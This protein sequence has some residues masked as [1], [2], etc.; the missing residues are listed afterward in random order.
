MVIYKLEPVL[1]NISIS[2]NI[3]KNVKNASKIKKLV[4]DGTI[5][6][7]ILKS[8]LVL[9]EFELLVA[10]NK[11][12]FQKSKNKL[13][14][15]NVFSEILFNLSPSNKISE[16]FKLFGI[17]EATTNLAVICLE[18]NYEDIHNLVDG[19]STVVSNL[20]ES[21]NKE[22]I[23]KLYKINESELKTS[24]LLDC[25]VSQLAAKDIR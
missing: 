1:S 4:E 16:C 7:A 9:D 21:C 11:A 17:D 20:A 22:A 8:D 13:K 6:A 5:H 24:T 12:F 19:D 14:T 23:L 10:T 3:Y 2:L 25:V 15:K 18:E